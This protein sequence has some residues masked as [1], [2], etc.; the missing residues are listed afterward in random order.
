M[1]EARSTVKHPAKRLCSLPGRIKA[2]EAEIT[3]PRVGGNIWELSQ[4]MLLQMHVSRS[5]TDSHMPRLPPATGE[6]VDKLLRP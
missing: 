1:V 6:S 4:H 5:C 2:D 3:F